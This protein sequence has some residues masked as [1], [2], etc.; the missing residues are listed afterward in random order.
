MLPDRVTNHENLLAIYQ[1][2][3]QFADLL[4]AAGSHEKA[5]YVRESCK[6]VAVSHVLDKILKGELK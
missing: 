1:H 3:Q 2:A 4:D 5:T 6:K